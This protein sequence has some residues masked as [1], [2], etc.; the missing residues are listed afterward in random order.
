MR[1]LILP[2]LLVLGAC[3]APPD[4]RQLQ[5]EQAALEGRL[6]SAN[7]EIAELNSQQAQLR[8][9]L[10]ERERVIAVLGEEKSSRVRESTSL[11]G[12]V[13]SFVQGQID[14]LK[15]F[16]L[17]GDLLDYIGSE[18]VQRPQHDDRPMQV[19]DL[20]HPVPRPGTLTGVGGYFTDQGSLVVK[21]LRPVQNQLVVVWESQPL[22]VQR[23]GQ[24]RINFPLVVGVSQGDIIGYWFAQ[25]G[26]VPF[27]TGTG[28]AGYR[29][30]QLAPGQSI[31]PDALRGTEHK[32]AYSIG[33]FGLLSEG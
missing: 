30:E 22:A 8:Q 21:V 16:L 7:Q 15:E 5:A 27:T 17:Q 24:Q 18:L 10:A 13:R 32:R 3:Q 11:R 2:A 1:Y 12:Q 14:A 29:E 25:P 20:A 9:E 31:R 23:P 4:V 28:Q 19:V 33:V 26:L 6:A